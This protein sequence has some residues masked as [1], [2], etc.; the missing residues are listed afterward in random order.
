ML[1]K[2]PHR[3]L[4]ILLALVLVLT[5]CS[6]PA[7]AT[8]TPTLPPPTNTDLPSPIPTNTAKPTST[9]RPTSTPDV[10]ATE[11]YDKVFSTVARFKDEGLIPSTNGRYKI[12]EDFDEQL[13]KIGWLQY[14]YFPGPVKHFVFSANLEWQTAVDTTD[15]SG[16]GIVFGVNDQGKYHEY[17][18]VVLDKSRI[19]FTSGKSGYYYEVGKT[20]GTG[21]L[22]FGNPAKAELTLLVYDNQAY[23]YVD[24]NFIGEYSL[25]KDKELRGKF[26]YGIISGTNKD[27]GTQCRID[28]ARMWQLT[29]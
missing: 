4:L 9:P 5:A 21:R 13:A 23:V 19:Y 29:E 2:Q 17:Y 10:I 11:M 7:R 8:L 18:G 6:S 15:T 16:C 1:T 25:A 3:T 26:G 27:Y 22:E 24:N 20:R 28:N 14:I 12:M